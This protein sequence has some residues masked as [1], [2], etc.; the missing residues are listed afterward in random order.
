MGRNIGGKGKEGK[1]GEVRE[2]ERKLEVNRWKGEM[3]EEQTFPGTG[4]GSRK[5]KEFAQL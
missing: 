4:K 1:G 2:G 3:E 5:T